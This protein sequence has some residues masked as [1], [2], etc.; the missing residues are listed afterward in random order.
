M[1]IPDKR[2]E[3]LCSVVDPVFIKLFTEYNWRF[4][5][6][7]SIL[8]MA[9]SRKVGFKSLQKISKDIGA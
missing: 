7:T 8:R 9:V 4:V 5:T 6:Y 2:E 1:I 3:E